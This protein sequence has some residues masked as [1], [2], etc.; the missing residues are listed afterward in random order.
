MNLLKWMALAGSCVLLAA[1]QPA[2]GSGDEARDAEASVAEPDA[3]DSEVLDADSSDA[4]ELDI[5][6]GASESDA[7]TAPDAAS[8]EADADTYACTVVAP[9][10][11]PDA[12]PRYA[13]VAPI[14]E[15]RCVVPCH[16]PDS[17]GGPWSLHDYRHVAD[18]RDTIR[19]NLLACTMPPRDAGVSIPA[20]ES[21]LILTWLR[22]DLPR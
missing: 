9:T 17:A 10:E 18:W 16:S 21:M 7:E 22:C 19:T 3:D 5:D 13:D 6:A 2:N 12:G 15:Q 11:C 20:D 8:G 14:I 1:C 4:S